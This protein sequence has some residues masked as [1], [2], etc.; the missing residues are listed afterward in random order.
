MPAT[1]NPI[2]S[3][4]AGENRA[5]TV[6]LSSALTEIEPSATPT[7]KITRNRLA[8][9]LLAKSTFLA[10]GGNWMNSTA[11]IVQK[12]LIAM[13]ARNTR[14][15]VRGVADQVIEARSRCKSSGSG[16]WCGGAG[17]ISRPVK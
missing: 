16:S 15:I 7:E 1:N 5:E 14:L 4:E 10:S 13:I 9:S 12:K 8:T 3:T 11:P 2:T 6:P 17:G